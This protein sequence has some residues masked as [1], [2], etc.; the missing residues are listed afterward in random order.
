MTMALR[1]VNNSINVATC[2]FVC[3]YEDGLG[4]TV[5][6][7]SNFSS[8]PT[9]VAVDSADFQRCENFL[10]G[11]LWLVYSYLIFF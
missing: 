3:A 6:G 9:L 7:D 10:R 4:V 11:C 1:N 8:I 5:N 2:V